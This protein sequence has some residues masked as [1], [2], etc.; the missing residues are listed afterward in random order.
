MYVVHIM[1]IIPD[2][3]SDSASGGGVETGIG[4]E[5]VWSVP[6]GVWSREVGSNESLE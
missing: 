3:G 4:R 5:R 1:Y 2:D 6:E